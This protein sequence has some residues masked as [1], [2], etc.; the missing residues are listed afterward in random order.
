M[1][2][3]R[4]RP[5]AELRSVLADLLRRWGMARRL[6]AYRALD[7]WAE[8]VGPGLARHSRAVDVEGGVLRVRAENGSWATELVFHKSSILR[9]L[10]RRGLRGVRALRVEAGP[11]AWPDAEPLAGPDEAAPERE[12]PELR[13]AAAASLEELRR[14]G[15]DGELL[16]RWR[17]VMLAEARRRARLAARK[18]PP[19]EGGRPAGDL[20]P[21]RRQEPAGG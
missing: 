21:G 6:E 7:L 5:P 10:H 8:V 14:G 2:E 12:I 16:E 9:E 1:S 3:H 20:G 11:G 15:L 13:P 17:R 19:G 4:E 18:A